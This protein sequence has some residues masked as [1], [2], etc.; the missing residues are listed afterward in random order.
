[1]LGL[2]INITPTAGTR[3]DGSYRYH[4]PAGGGYGDGHRDGHG[5]ATFSDWVELFMLPEHHFLRHT[6]WANVAFLGVAGM[7]RGAHKT[8]NRSCTRHNHEK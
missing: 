4:R 1:M 5:D 6:G 7:L 8:Q 2:C 3:F